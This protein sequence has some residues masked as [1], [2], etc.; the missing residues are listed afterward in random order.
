MLGR[1]P[2][3]ELELDPVLEEMAARGVA[4]EV[5]GAL[6]RLDASAEVIRRAVAMGVKLVIS[7]DSHHVS[8]L[9]RMS[10]GAA[11][12]RRGWA[13]P[14]AVLNTLPRQEFLAALQAR[15]EEIG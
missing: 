3:I 14:E 12:A 8:E 10:Y 11:N 4:L 7:T 2:G 15:R 5:N 9:K 1:R 13:T 6:D